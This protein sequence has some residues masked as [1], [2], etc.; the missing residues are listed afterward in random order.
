[1]RVRPTPRGI[2]LSARAFTSAGERKASDSCMV[3]ERAPRLSRAASDSMFAARPVTRSSNHRRA[4]AIEASNRERASED[5]TRG[6][7]PCPSGGAM[8]SRCTRVGGLDQGTTIV[9]RPIVSV[10]P[11]ERR[12]SI[13]PD[14][15]ETRSTRS[16]AP[17]SWSGPESLASPRPLV[18]ND[19]MRFRAESQCLL[20]NWSQVRLFV[21]RLIP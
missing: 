4:A 21:D 12:I 20:T 13:S 3:A 9:P 18:A 7:S 17:S 11:S 16:R 2:R 1:M 8:M 15:I 6:S 5:I 14:R 10:A 19:L